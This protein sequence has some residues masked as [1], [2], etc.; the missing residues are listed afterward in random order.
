M[1][2][3]KPNA[4][5][6]TFS[7]LTSFRTG[8]KID[9]RSSS[10]PL[11][12]NP[13]TP[14]N[15]VFRPVATYIYPLTPYQLI[16]HLIVNVGSHVF[17]IS[18]FLKKFESPPSSIMIILTPVVILSQTY[19]IAHSRSVRDRLWCFSPIQRPTSTM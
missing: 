13:T 14:V 15:I 12:R 11:V 3:F 17:E 16:R 5:K 6:I 19:C 2:R 9:L 18:G 7:T 4:I 10:S 1:R 8:E